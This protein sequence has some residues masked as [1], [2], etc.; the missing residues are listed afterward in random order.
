MSR[1]RK[2]RLPVWMAFVPALFIGLA[3]CQSG[4]DVSEVLDPGAADGTPVAAE[5]P[6]G[7]QKP[8]TLGKGSMKVVML[9]P[10]SARGQDGDEGRKMLDGASSWR[11]GKRSLTLTIEDTRGDAA[12]PA[13]W[14]SRPWDREPRW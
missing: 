14:Q 2:T 7:P 6:A 11:Y 12:S 13:R 10:L 9:L 5:A 1:G 4:G 8:M 3:A